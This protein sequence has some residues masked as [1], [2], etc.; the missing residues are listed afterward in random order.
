[1]KKILFLLIILLGIISCNS[2]IDII[3]GD[4]YFKQY[5]FDNLYYSDKERVKNIRKEIDSL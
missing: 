3:Q 1:M 5:D 4:L 2:K